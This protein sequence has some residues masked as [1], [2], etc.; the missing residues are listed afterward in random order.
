[1]LGAYVLVMG[2]LKDQNERAM[3]AKGQNWPKYYPIQPKFCPKDQDKSNIWPK[4]EA[5]DKKTKNWT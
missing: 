4:I 1:M 3:D 5:K 2:G